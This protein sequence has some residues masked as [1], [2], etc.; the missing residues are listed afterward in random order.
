[1]GESNEGYNPFSQEIV[2]E[3]RV[4]GYA[5]GVHGVVAPADGDDA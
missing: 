5:S 2:Y 4:E 1:M 3:F